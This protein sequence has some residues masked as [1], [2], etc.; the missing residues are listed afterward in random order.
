NRAEIRS[1]FDSIV[2][3][4]DVEEFIDTPVKRFSSGMVVRLGFSVAA[5]L[6][7]DILLLDEVLA[8]G[9]SVFQKKC[10]DR[11]LSLKNRCTIVFIS[12]DLSAVQQLCD[13]VIVMNAG[14]IVQD[15]APDAALAAYHTLTR[16]RSSSRLVDASDAGT[17]EISCIDF[18]DPH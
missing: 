17:A 3:F 11:V 16:F 12:H 10:I 15:A 18:L 2:D 6:D 4:A 7:P 8:V 5:H 14:R 1:K 9:D 13:R